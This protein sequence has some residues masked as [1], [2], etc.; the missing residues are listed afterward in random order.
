[1]SEEENKRNGFISAINHSSS[2]G[3]ELILAVSLVIIVFTVSLQIVYRYLFNS[4]LIWTDE[5]SRLAFC[6]FTFTGSALAS[7]EKKH[8]EV[9]YF[10]NKFSLKWQ[11]IVDFF[12]TLIVF[13][14]SLLVLYAVVQQMIQGATMRSASTRMPLMIFPLSLLLGFI[15]ITFYNFA[16]LIELLK[17]DK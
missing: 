12:I 14:F 15:G 10:Y 11:K 5:M 7:Y 4:P 1:M 8:L 2:K 9:S 16:D 3:Y 17:K 13:I 6:W